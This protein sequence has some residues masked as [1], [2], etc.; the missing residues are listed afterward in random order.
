MTNNKST[1]VL[2]VY[3]EGFYYIMDAGEK[4]DL[5]DLAQKMEARGFDVVHFSPLLALLTKS[6]NLENSHVAMLVDKDAYAKDLPDNMTGT[7]VYGQGTE[8]R[9]PVVFVL[10]TDNGYELKPLKGQQ[11][12]FLLIEFLNAATG[13]LLRQPTREEADI[14]D[15][16]DPKEITVPLSELDEALGIVNLC[17]DTLFIVLPDEPRY[18]FVDT[19]DLFYP[20]MDKIEANIEAH[21]G[22]MID[23]WRFVD[24]CQTPIDI[25]SRVRFK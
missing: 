14:F 20:I 24:S 5:G 10:E 18:E 2:S 9:G 22:H 25:R 1:G 21:G 23:E 13:G 16:A 11:R 4:L 6:L 17:R 8:M 12:M 3:P 15:D 7:I 19:G